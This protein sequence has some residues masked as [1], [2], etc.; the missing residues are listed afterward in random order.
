MLPGLHKAFLHAGLVHG[1]NVNI[2]WGWPQAV[3][4]TCH[5]AQPVSQ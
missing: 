3:T 4:A 5:V 1:H 2:M